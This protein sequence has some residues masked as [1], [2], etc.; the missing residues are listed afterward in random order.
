MST[1]YQTMRGVTY[2]PMPV[3]IW[4]WDG[5]GPVGR[6]ELSESVEATWSERGTGIAVIDTPLNDL[7]RLLLDQ[8]SS[9]LVV[10]RFNGVRH[11]SSVVKAVAYADDDASED[12]RVKATTASAWS[13]LEGELIPPDPTLPLGQQGAREAF[14]MTGP[15][16]TVVKTVIRHGAERLG[17]PILIMPDRR[18]GPTVTVRS[19]FDSV[20]DLVESALLSSGWHLSLEAW[21]PGDPGIEDFSLTRPTIIAEVDPYLDVPGLMFSAEAQDLESWEL[22]Y[23]RPSATNVITSIPT[24]EGTEDIEFMYSSFS[25]GEDQVTPWG[26]RETFAKG[27]EGQTAQEVGIPEL[28]ENKAAVD[29]DAT[30]APALAWEFGTDGVT[31]RQYQIG[32]NATVVL[33]KVGSVVE[34]ISE[35]TVKLTPSSLTVTPKVSTPDTRDKDLYS[36]VAQVSKRVDRVNKRR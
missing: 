26:K 9:T 29:L 18:R 34:V 15:L 10:I 32:N 36:L 14:T 25:M 3:E 4:Q 31:P 11:V 2:D 30:V 8:K 16:E 13:M 5:T 20:A 1:A 19:E 23:D 12:V 17:H 24:P 6:L 7:S 33:P 28:M 35:V 27:E 22:A 21:L